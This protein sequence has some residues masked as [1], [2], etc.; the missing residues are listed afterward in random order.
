MSQPARGPSRPGM[1]RSY[2]VALVL[3]A[4]VIAGLLWLSRAF[5]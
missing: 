4:L 2:V 1:T 5:S 3:E